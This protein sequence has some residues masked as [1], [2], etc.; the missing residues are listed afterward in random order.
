MGIV[1]VHRQAARKA[2]IDAKLVK[3][4]AP[5]FG[6]ARPDDD[7]TIVKIGAWTRDVNKKSREKKR[8]VIQ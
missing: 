1:L 8:E 3:M 5:P 7:R 2:V 6:G 4:G